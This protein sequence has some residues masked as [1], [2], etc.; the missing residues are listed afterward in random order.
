MRPRVLGLILAVI[1]GV[2]LAE[3]VRC[4]RNSLPESVSE[5]T[6]ESLASA[7]HRLGAPNHQMTGT[8]NTLAGKSIDGMRL[9]TNLDRVNESE[10]LTVSI[11]TSRCFVVG[12]RELLLI[13]TSHGRTVFKGGTGRYV[14]P[15]IVTHVRN[16]RATPAHESAH[17]Q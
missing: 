10:D 16:E 5:S 12:T 6:L 2:A 1:L 14:L 7:T 3:F 17:G 15:I 8:L 13:T 9:P 4:S 11:W